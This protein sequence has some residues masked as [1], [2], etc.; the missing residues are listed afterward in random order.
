[1][2]DDKQHDDSSPAA[3]GT[4]TPEQPGD[5]TASMQR[6]DIVGG[7]ESPSAEDEA[8]TEM[9]AGGPRAPGSDATSI[10]P[11][12]SDPWT[13]RAEV[14]IGEGQVRDSVPPESGYPGEPRRVWWSPILIGVVVLILLAIMAVAVWF[15]LRK[16]PA[17]VPTAS[18]APVQTSELPSVAPTPTASVAPSV[19]AV[20]QKVP[21]LVGM[22]QQKA[23]DALTALGLNP[24]IE[25]R[26]SDSADPGT[27]LEVSPKPGSLVQPGATVRLFVAVPVPSSPTPSP[28]PSSASPSPSS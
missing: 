20:P 15:A 17:V 13:G 21:D 7:D 5:E 28:S 25:Y 10:M 19:T 22:P 16:T 2:A 3:D 8:T 24:E 9:P 1:M 12:A 26:P 23:I 18:P 27:V 11:P 4:P 6:D 14:P